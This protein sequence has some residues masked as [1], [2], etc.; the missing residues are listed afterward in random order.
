MPTYTNL[1]ERGVYTFQNDN[2]GTL[3]YSFGS[4]A[5]FG[6]KVLEDLEVTGNIETTGYLKEIR[7]TGDVIAFHSSD[8]RM[9]DNIFII[10]DPLEKINALRG[11]TFEWNDKGP[12]WTKSEEWKRARDVGV[13]AQEVKKVLPE[14]VKERK[15]EEG[16]EWLAVDYKR[17]VPLL[18]EGIKEQQKQIDN[19]KDCIIK[20]ENK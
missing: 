4:T 20:L 18:I 1:Q 11:V 14:A 3:R 19:L 2:A 10:K 17:L 16:Q 5:L 8:E 9:K 12:K 6:F 7:A 13:I 15:S